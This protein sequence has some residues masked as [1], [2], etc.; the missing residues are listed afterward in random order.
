[1]EQR[2]EAVKR[3]EEAVAS[4]AADQ[5]MAGADLDER[6]CLLR[7]KERNLSTAP[8]VKV[9]PNEWADAS[10]RRPSTTS[11]NYL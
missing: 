11:G 5:A 6:E 2:E 3:R 7:E 1:M 9:E 10:R 4:A 8:P